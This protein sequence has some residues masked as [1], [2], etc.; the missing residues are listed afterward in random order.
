MKLNS[1]LEIEEQNRDAI[2]WFKSGIFWRAYNQSAFLTVTHFRAFKTIK[3]FY[4]T[5][6]REAIYVGF[7]DRILVDMVDQAS[8]FGAQVKPSEQQITIT[9][10]T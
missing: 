10:N 6:G 5:L 4:K 2:H 9:S 8:N 1:I 7:P 3:R